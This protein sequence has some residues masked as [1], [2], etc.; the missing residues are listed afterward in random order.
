MQAPGCGVV[1]VAQ[2][3]LFSSLLRAG[4]VTPNPSSC[5]G[6]ELPEVPARRTVFHPVKLTKF[7]HFRDSRD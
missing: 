1:W 5:P 3:E 4:K 6:P 7:S 2:R